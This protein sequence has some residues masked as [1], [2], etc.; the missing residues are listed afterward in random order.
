MWTLLHRRPDDTFVIQH[1]GWPYHVTVSDPLYAE[2]AA[3]ADGV[4]LPPEQAPQPIEVPTP[5][6][7][8][9][10]D[11]MAQLLSLQAQIAALP[12]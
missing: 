8:T 7:P 12:E 2:V 4:D 6:Q 3:A 10:A 5:P 9:K 1:N 11:L